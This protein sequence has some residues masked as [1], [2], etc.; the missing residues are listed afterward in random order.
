MAFGLVFN[1]NNKIPIIIVLIETLFILSQNATEWQYRINVLLFASSD[2]FAMFNQFILM[3]I[4]PIIIVDND[5]LLMA[6]TF[7]FSINTIQLLYYPD[8][9]EIVH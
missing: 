6:L 3:L 9:T 8:E 1:I 2:I 5:D 7:G 4:D